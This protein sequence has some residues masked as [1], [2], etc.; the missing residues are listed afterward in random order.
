LLGDLKMNNVEWLQLVSD[1]ILPKHLDLLVVKGI[2]K[3]SESKDSVIYYISQ[4]FAIKFKKH[5][6]WKKWISKKN[7]NDS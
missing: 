4:S 3:R 5:S 6:W 2:V 1:V 7:L